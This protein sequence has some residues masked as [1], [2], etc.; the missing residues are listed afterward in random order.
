MVYNKKDI[1]NVPLTIEQIKIISFELAKIIDEY[2]ETNQE[3]IEILRI[4]NFTAFR[5]VFNEDK[6]A[7]K[8][9]EE[10]FKGKNEF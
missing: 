9:L 4:F 3:L 1:V 5:H 8:L 7:I 10:Y 2:S 6:E